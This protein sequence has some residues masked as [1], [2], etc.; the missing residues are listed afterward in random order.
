MPTYRVIEKK[1]KSFV[2]GRLTASDLEKLINK[3]AQDEWTL[4]RIVAGETARVLLGDKNMFF[5]IFRK[6]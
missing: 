5:L 2:H 4:D 3:T 1:Q 6:D